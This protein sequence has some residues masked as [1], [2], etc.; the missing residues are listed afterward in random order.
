MTEAEKKLNKYNFYY[1]RY[2]VYK[3]SIGKSKEIK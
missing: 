1:D 3:N 2:I